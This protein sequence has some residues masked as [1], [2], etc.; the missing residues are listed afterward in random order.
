MKN[1]ILFTTL[2]LGLSTVYGSSF[3]IAKAS[4]ENNIVKLEAGT[5]M[6]AGAHQYRSF[7]TR[8]FC[9]SV[10]GLL[11][12]HRE[13]V[14]KSHLEYLITHRRA[15]NLVPLYVD[16]MNPVYRVIAAT[17]FKMFGGSALPI[18]ESIAPYYLVNGEYEV[19]DSNILV[20]YAA[21]EYVAATKD[22]EWFK[23][24]AADFKAIFDFYQ[25]K[26]HDGLIVQGE[27]AD[28][29]DSSERKGKTFLTN[30]IYYQ[31]GRDY[32]YLNKEQLEKLR[33]D[34]MKVFFDEKTGLFK[35][36]EGRD[37]ISLDGVLW[38]ID[39]DLLVDSDNLY[40]KLAAHEL[41][42]KYGIP[43]FATYPSYN[44]S[45]L[46]IQVKIVGLQEYHGNLFWSWLTA[47]A[48][49][50]AYK[51]SDKPMFEKIH[52][53]LNKW[54]ERDQMVYE[55][56]ENNDEHKPVNNFLYKSE[57][58]FSWGSAFVLDLENT[59]QAM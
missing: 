17:V 7:W 2:F 20:L 51:K 55:I 11:A 49:K 37:N 8:D 13:D 18:K 14:V 3:D 35:S 12:I 50:V 52:S 36:I 26:I 22:T 53:A 45:D 15:D 47:Y 25:T 44:S 30:L 42:T 54:L 24:H 34:I 40:R 56:Y 4:I 1:I 23:K 33:T 48:A 10:K 28:W 9:L 57:G 39:H 31:M 41:F 59:I 58:P 32:N 21:Q 27:H 19:I 46:Y 5:F 43:G 16:S 6:S 38:A 29:Q